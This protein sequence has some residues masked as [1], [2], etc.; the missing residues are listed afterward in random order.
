MKQTQQSLFPQ[1][2]A[3]KPAPVARV[4]VPQRSSPVATQRRAPLWLALRL[5]DLSLQTFLRGH[6]PDAPLA[7]IDSVGGAPRIHAVNAHAAGNG[8]SP[9]MTLA[10]AWARLPGLDVRERDPVREQQLL[11]RLAVWAGRFTPAVHLDEQALL[12][13]VRGSVELFNGAD[14]LRETVCQGVEKLGITANTALASTPRAALWL[15]RARREMHVDRKES[16]AGTLGDLPLFVTGF[17][18]N[19]LEKLRGIG[20]CTLRDLMRLPRDGI[21]RR[22]GTHVLRALD[23]AL[24]RAPDVRQPFLP[25]K[26]FSTRIELLY[27]IE[28]AGR[29]LHPVHLLLQELDG[30]LQATQ[31]GVSRL[32]LQLFHRDRTFTKMTLGFADMTRDPV[33]IR[34]LMEQKFETLELPAPILDIVL[35][36]EEMTALAARDRALFAEQRADESWPQLVERLRVRL[37]AQAVSGIEQRADH[38]PERAWRPVAPGVARDGSGLAGRP[39]WL[40]EQPQ[41]LR[42]QEGKPVANGG[43]LEI[44]DGPERIE[45]GWWDDAGVSR[46]Y[47][48]A[49]D[50]HGCR[51]W[52]CR[53]IRTGRWWLQGIYG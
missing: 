3:A 11:Q 14:A 36:A 49:R 20:V 50:R 28:D 18:E 29:L 4:H 32:Q 53:E 22:Y 45:T 26:R 13:E 52:I 51:L 16:L 48:I 30:Y 15:A 5:P 1:L 27:E 9:G 17:E 43:V 23:Q 25:P 8:V 7:I 47:Y 37:G 44:L 40:L 35:R 42:V 39:P 34:D 12:L 41:A 38:R 21:A 19:L 2:P 24:G 6:V 33:R 46:D 31:Q 10:A